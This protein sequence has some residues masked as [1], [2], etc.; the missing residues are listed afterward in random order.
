VSAPRVGDRVIVPWRTHRHGTTI[1]GGWREG[2][3]V[4]I[5]GHGTGGRLVVSSHGYEREYPA[6]EVKPYPQHERDWPR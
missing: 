2:S 1:I 3:V 5:R 6:F 4:A